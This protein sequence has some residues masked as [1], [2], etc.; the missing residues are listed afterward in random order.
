MTAVAK[1]MARG[2][3]GFI[4]ATVLILATGLVIIPQHSWAGGRGGGQGSLQVLGELPPPRDALSGQIVYVDSAAR[5]AY[6]T[7]LRGIAVRVA[8]YDL[9]PA[10]P[11]LLRESELGLA[12]PNSL[13]PTPNG[14]AFD[15]RRR[16]LVFLQ[17][18]TLDQHIVVRLLDLRSLSPVPA[19][20]GDWDFN[21]PKRL[22]GFFPVGITY[23][24]RDDRIYLIGAMTYGE[25]LQALGSQFGQPAQVP[26]VVALDAV[27]GSLKWARPVPECQQVLY[28]SFRGSLIARSEMRD[29]LYFACTTGSPGVVLS[30]NPG[31]SGVVRLAIDPK[32]TSADALRFRADFFAI[33]GAYSANAYHG[34]AVFDPKTDQLFLQSMSTD[35]PGAWVFDG[36]MPGWAGFIAAPESAKGIAQYSGINSRTGQYYMGSG[37]TGVGYIVVTNDRALPIPQGNVYEGLQP[38]WTIYTD[39]RSERLFVMKEK[40]AGKTRWLV[41]ADRTPEFLL[42]EGADFDS[43]TSDLDEGPDTEV[44]F[45]SGVSGYGAKATLVGGYGGAWSGLIDPSAA[46][47]LISAEDV[48]RGR[49]RPADRALTLAGVPSL[50]LRSGSSSAA[51]QAGSL[52]PDSDSD[53]GAA[54]ESLR[55]EQISPLVAAQI[56]DLNNTLGDS[57]PQWLRDAVNTAADEMKEVGPV[58]TTSPLPQMRE[59]AAS[60]LEWPWQ[61]RT[62]LDGGGDKAHETA[63][64]HGGTVDITCD[65]ATLSANASARWGNFVDGPLS[66]GSTSFDSRG[67]RDPKTGSSTLIKST[68]NGIKIALDGIGTLKIGHIESSVTTLAR[69]RP[70]TAKATWE[71]AIEQVRVLDAAGKPI[72]VP[73]GCDD[74]K[75]CQ[76][77]AADV[78]HALM[79]RIRLY[80]P[81]ADVEQT[82]KGAFATVQKTFE[83]FLNDSTVNNDQSRAVPALQIEVYK[84]GV[85]RSRLLLQFAAIQANSIYTIAPSLDSPPIEPPSIIPENGII[86]G[87]PLTGPPVVGG[88]QAL[89]Q[90]SA[91]APARGILALLV[92]S[93]FEALHAAGIWVLFGAAVFGVVRRR[94]FSGQLSQGDW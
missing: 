69:G 89:P 37:G 24:A 8:E 39:E 64:N 94:M 87:Q 26:V 75:S 4:A 51:A 30:N 36:R 65:L 50:D 59:D 66:I 92:R 77:L 74:H 80:V 17:K 44:N 46:G 63:S 45:V 13:T 76:Q 56:R 23:S 71:S 55:S 7:F 81:D 15:S 47:F 27:D 53:L 20:A 1:G 28:Q 40:K 70:G 9:T 6:Y 67:W 93:P 2:R 16:R 78:T 12:N 54:R 11:R 82:P 43:L 5:R 21:S 79:G 52:D 61:S 35:T 57:S 18:D 72:P 73:Q 84:D 60:G 85:D 58:E 3:V 86:P 10:L 22:P 25:T 49:V 32:G 34:V 29:A 19:P 48:S 83:D 42:P 88:P 62:C 38:I 68:A 14:W 90:G 31:Y 41:V 33:S 91:D